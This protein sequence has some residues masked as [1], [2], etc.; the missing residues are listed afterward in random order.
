[1]HECNGVSADGASATKL[2]HFATSVI[3][4]THVATSVVELVQVVYDVN[5]W[6]QLLG[7]LVMLIALNE[8]NGIVKLVNQ[9]IMQVACNILQHSG[10]SPKF[11]VEALNIMV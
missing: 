6:H 4:P 5:L 10:L 8:Q 2:T 3:E 1:M 9:T 11:W 7:H